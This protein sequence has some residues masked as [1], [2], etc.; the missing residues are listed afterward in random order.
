[1]GRIEAWERPKVIEE[2][3]Q[4]YHENMSFIDKSGKN[5]TCSATQLKDLKKVVS[6]LYDYIQDLEYGCIECDLRK[7]DWCNIIADTLLDDD[8]FPYEEDGF[9]W[10]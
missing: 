1:M 4:L 7:E 6:Q 10:H 9:S 5:G 2:L 8:N 3:K